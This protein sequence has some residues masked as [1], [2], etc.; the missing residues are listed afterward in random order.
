MNVTSRVGITSSVSRRT[1]LPRATAFGIGL[2]LAISAFHCRETP[3]PRTTLH[4]DLLDLLP[5]AEISR[6]TNAIDFG[7][8]S[9]RP[10][11]LEGWV[12][13]EQT[14]RPEWESHLWS[15]GSRSTLELFV[16]RPPG[17][18]RELSLHPYLPPNRSSVLRPSCKVARLPGEWPGG[19]ADIPRTGALRVRSGGPGLILDPRRERTGVPLSH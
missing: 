1:P 4:T 10:H 18:S 11:L 17:S 3:G 9:A 5:I 14:P 12:P 7:R 6:E 13:G 15:L 2:L 16:S 8:S 19:G